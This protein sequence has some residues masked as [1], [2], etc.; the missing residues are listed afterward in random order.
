[1]LGAT[2]EEDMGKCVT[3]PALSLRQP[4]ASL[5]LHGV[6][7]LE[8]RNRPTLQP[9]SGPMAIHVSHR[10]EPFDSPLVASAVAI[11]RQRY[12]DEAISSLF[13]LPQ[14]LAQGHG[15]V[16][17]LIDVEATWPADIFDEIEQSQLTEQAAQPV[18][19]TYIT[20]LRNPRWFKYPIRTGGSNKLWHQPI[21]VD[22]LP[23][24]TR[25]DSRG[26]LVSSEGDLPSANRASN[27]T[28]LAMGD[29]L[30]LGLL[31]GDVVR[32]RQDEAGET[33]KKRKKLDKALREIEA[34]KLR[35]AQGMRLERTQEG[36]IERETELRCALAELLAGNA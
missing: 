1:M 21:P 26:N 34:L 10:E 13:T 23:E 15:C 27:D 8:A 30:A 36:K 31:G 19:G 25:V 32:Q 22:A 24:G 28:P 29:D 35:Q 14:P 3:L 18:G 6:K 11:L 5:V 33:E 7:Q 9:L 12:T 4:F 17:G 2:S 20:Q 16:V